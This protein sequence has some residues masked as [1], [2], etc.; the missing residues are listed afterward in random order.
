MSDAG[1]VQ[2]LDCPMLCQGL[3]FA[4]ETAGHEFVLMCD[5]CATVWREPGLVGSE[6]FVQPFGP[7]WVVAG[8]IHVRPGT[9]RWASAD[10]VASRDWDPRFVRPVEGSRPAGSGRPVWA[11]S[12]WL[13]WAVI[14]TCAGLLVLGSTADSRVGVALVLAI[15]GLPA[16]WYLWWSHKLGGKPHIVLAERDPDDQGLFW[17]GRGFLLMVVAVTLA[18][19]IVDSGGVIAAAGLSL[20]V[21]LLTLVRIVRSRS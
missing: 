14:A 21:A 10:S 8:S 7:T 13:G 18:I 3:V 15:F 19:V 4:L 12:G 16:P 17:M 20:L 5:D 9:T 11:E 6:Q 1:W 2:P